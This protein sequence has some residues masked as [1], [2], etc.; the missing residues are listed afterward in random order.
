MQEATFE[1]E[2]RIFCDGFLPVGI[3]E[4]GRG[5]LAGPVVAAAVLIKLEAWSMEQGATS[6]GFKLQASSS[7]IE[8]D[9]RWKLVRDSKKLSPKQREIAFDFVRERFH[10]GLGV[11][12][13]GTIDRV[14]ILQATFLAMKAALAEL[15]RNARRVTGNTRQEVSVIPSVVEESSGIQERSLRF[16]RDDKEWI[17]L[18]DGNQEIPNI[19]LKQ[20]TIVDGDALVKSIAAAS[21]VAKVTRDRLMLELDQRYPEY[22]FARHK[23]Y[24]TREHMDALRR[25]GPTDEHRMSF[26]P[27]KL[28]IPENVNRKLALLAKR[29]GS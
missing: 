26:D 2:R 24:G 19:S 21:V 28:S 17:L 7:K 20:E 4:A 9:K 29:K 10:V 6:P 15:R 14:N 25:H 3:D 8:E 18:I 11:I 13:P 5:P 12:G 1:R 27:V 16:G 23:G 22:G